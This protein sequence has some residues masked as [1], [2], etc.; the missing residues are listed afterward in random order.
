MM[1]SF[2][3]GSVSLGLLGVRRGSN[4]CATCGFCSG[5]FGVTVRDDLFGVARWCR[6]EKWFLWSEAVEGGNE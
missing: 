5:R 6:I 2:R 3:G 1:L 4:S